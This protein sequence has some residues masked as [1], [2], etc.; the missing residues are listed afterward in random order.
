[1][2]GGVLL[3]AWTRRLERPAGWSVWQPDGDDRVAAAKQ[4]AEHVGPQYRLG[5]GD[6]L[7]AVQAG[8]L[9]IADLPLSVALRS[10]AN[11]GDIQLIDGKGVMY[12]LNG[13][14]PRGSITRGTPSEE[15]HLLLRRE[16]LELALYTFRYRDDVDIVVALL[17]PP[18][19]DAGHD[20]DDDGGPADAGAVLPP[21]RPARR[22]RHRR[23]AAPSRRRRRGPRRCR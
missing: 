23:S 4:I 10:S 5:D 12:T 17:P 18:P 7:V 13:L 11:G 19:P 9:E 21:G 22:A 15:R 16:A 3:A 8:P 20:R 14:G 1:M 6:Q 2:A